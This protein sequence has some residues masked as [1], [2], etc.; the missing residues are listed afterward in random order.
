MKIFSIEKAKGS[1][2]GVILKEEGRLLE[3]LEISQYL[4]WKHKKHV[5]L[6]F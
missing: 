3:F 1:I 5:S 4:I 2:H 6:N